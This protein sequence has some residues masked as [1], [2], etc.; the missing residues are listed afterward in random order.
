MC[1]AMQGDLWK[2]FLEPSLYGTE[3][4]TLG[5]SRG[6]SVSYYVP[7]LSAVQLLLPVPAPQTAPQQPA[8]QHPDAKHSAVSPGT[9]SPADQPANDRQQGSSTE[10]LPHS[11]LPRTG[12]LYHIEDEWQRRS[13]Q[14]H[15]CHR[16]QLLSSLLLHFAHGD[17][18]HTAACKPLR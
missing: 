14:V 16:P 10:L 1:G 11:D 7:Y 6:P 5:G 3:V 18:Q 15:R 4:L 13:T 2:W 9:A 8:S 12:R 17:A